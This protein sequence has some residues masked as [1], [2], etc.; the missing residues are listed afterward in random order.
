[1][2]TV[3]S[4]ASSYVQTC[5]RFFTYEIIEESQ[6]CLW[7]KISNLSN[8]FCS[9]YCRALKFVTHEEELEQILFINFQQKVQNIFH[10]LLGVFF[11]PFCGILTWWQNRHAYNPEQPMA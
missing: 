2:S 5:E 7:V 11:V 10:T 8:N 4:T 1:M 3:D 6:K 9:I